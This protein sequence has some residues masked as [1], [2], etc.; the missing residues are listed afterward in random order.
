MPCYVL[1]QLTDLL[2]NELQCKLGFL[3]QITGSM[4]TETPD[5]PNLKQVS[6]LPC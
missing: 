4:P 3:N 5:A 1:P 6:P 2:G